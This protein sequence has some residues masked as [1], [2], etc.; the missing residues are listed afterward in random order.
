[1]SIKQ[2]LATVVAAVIESLH[3]L[4]RTTLFRQDLSVSAMFLEVCRKMCTMK[5]STSN[6][7]GLTLPRLMPE[8]K[9]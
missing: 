6:G 2:I 1:M 9:P 3:H 8:K 5:V 4:N 7:R